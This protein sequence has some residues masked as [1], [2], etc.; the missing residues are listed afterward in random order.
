MTATAKP[1]AL[2]PNAEEWANYLNLNPIAGFGPFA[3][4]AVSV[5]DGV[6][7][8][9][10]DDPSTA[11]GIWAN[12]IEVE[13]ENELAVQWAVYQG[14]CVDPVAVYDDPAAAEFKAKQLL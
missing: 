3:P 4:V 9:S 11:I 6:Q 10:S 5:Y 12:A 14:D 13:G 1:F 8:W 2:F 7:A